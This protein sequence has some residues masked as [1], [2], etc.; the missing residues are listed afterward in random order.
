M[1]NPLDDD[2][3]DDDF[4]EDSDAQE[5]F[6]LDELNYSKKREKESRYG[7]DREKFK[8]IKEE[9]IELRR[10]QMWEAQKAEEEIKRQNNIENKIKEINNKILENKKEID[11]LASFP[12]HEEK[13]YIYAMKKSINN[14]LDFDCIFELYIDNYE[15]KDE[16][17]KIIKTA[18]MKFAHNY[19]NEKVLKLNN[20][21]IKI[22]Q[23]IVDNLLSEGAREFLKQYNDANHKWDK[24]RELTKENNY[25]LDMIEGLKFNN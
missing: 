14:P 25:Y 24:I 2:D 16:L 11:F 7:F 8:K 12:S 13:R 4:D 17:E 3:F 9:D 1:Y 23:D 18:T 6:L 21:G 5:R 22:T 20:E 19:K 10:R 15:A